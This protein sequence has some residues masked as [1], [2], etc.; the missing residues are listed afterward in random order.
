MKCLFAPRVSAIFRATTLAMVL[1]GLTAGCGKKSEVALADAAKPK[2]VSRAV[3][4]EADSL[5][6]D[7]AFAIQL[8][9]YPRAA[10]SLTKALKLRVDIPEWWL[11][12]AVMEKRLGKPGEA[13]S[14]YK[15]ALAIHE[16]RYEITKNSAH[17]M[18]QLYL[19]LLLNREK[20]ARSLLENSLRRH[21]T[22]AK[23]KEFVETKGLDKLIQDPYIR[24]NKV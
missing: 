16:S 14:A 22:D 19:L 4:A 23:M 18:P 6:S 11:D 5:A 8:K 21:P 7:A 15:K 1:A 24:E 17:L 9:D 13:K 3:M 20:D 2:Q 12:F 10:D